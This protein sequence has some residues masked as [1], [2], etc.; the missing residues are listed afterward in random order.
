M[1]ELGEPR[2]E[3]GVEA[4]LLRGLIAR[5]KRGE[6]HRE[7]GA[8]MKLLLGPRPSRTG[9]AGDSRRGLLI[10]EGM[11]LSVVLGARRLS[12]LVEG[13]AIALA[14]LVL[15]IGKRLLD[16]LPKHELTTQNAHGLAK[17]LAD[18]LLEHE[19]LI[20][21]QDAKSRERDA[22]LAERIDKLVSAIGVL[23]SGRSNQPPAQP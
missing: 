19:R 16:G 8:A 22:K 5:V 14:N 13:E 21:E 11:A 4:R 20:R 2:H 18:N 12:Q 10:A 6:L 17:S 3:L 23:A 9:V 7:P 15:A 1:S